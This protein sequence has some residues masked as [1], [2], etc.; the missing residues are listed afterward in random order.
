MLRPM[1]KI[2]VILTL[3]TLLSCKT[4]KFNSE[5]EKGR[6]KKELFTDVFNAMI[7]GDIDSAIKAVPDSGDIFVGFGEIVRTS[8]SEIR[9]NYEKDLSQMKCESYEFA[10]GPTIIFIDSHNCYGTAKIKWTCIL[11]SDSTKTKKEYIL[12]TLFVAKK[13][14]NGNWVR[15]A[16]SQ[17]E[18]HD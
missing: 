10:D 1:F 13:Q 4:E 8:K 15:V 2:S 3:L 18:K 11:A 9:K 12:S 5:A 7:V 6:I 17:S 16:S 14:N